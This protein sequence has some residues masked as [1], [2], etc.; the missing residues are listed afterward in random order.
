MA[1]DEQ[2]YDALFPPSGDEDMDAS[3]PRPFDNVELDALAGGGDAAAAAAAAGESGAQAGAGR[4]GRAPPPPPEYVSPGVA[5]AMLTGA[6]VPVTNIWEILTSCSSSGEEEPRVGER[7]LTLEEMYM[8]HGAGAG[9]GAAAAAAAGGTE[10]AEGDER[11]A[12]APR[13][14]RSTEERA[15]RR[16]QKV[17][18]SS[19]N[20]IGCSFAL[21]GSSGSK[22]EHISVNKGS[23]MVSLFVRYASCTHPW[24]VA[25][26]LH[27]FYMTAIYEPLKDDPATR[28]PKWSTHGIYVHFFH[29]TRAPQTYLLQ[30][31]DR[32]EELSRGLHQACFVKTTGGTGVEPDVK[33]ITTLLRV[34]AQLDRFRRQRVDEY[35]FHVPELPVDVDR[36]GDHL[37]ANG[38]FTV[39]SANPND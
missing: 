8:Q 15:N 11:D 13:V 22:G 38:M 21:A 9:A 20:C 30:Q 29:H 1:M 28:V 2:V 3:D 31:I 37:A 34:D 6:P 17:Y 25:R 10:P 23:Q 12:P 7:Q 19:L 35:N 39:G 26:I 4:G 5:H 36:A 16:K 18:Q 33:V 32:Y 27:K 14:Y 24:A